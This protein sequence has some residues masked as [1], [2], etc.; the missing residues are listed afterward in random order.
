MQEQ[1]VQPDSNC[2]DS[3]SNSSSDEGLENRSSSSSEDEEE[4]DDS[5]QEKENKT[6]GGGEMED[7][8]VKRIVDTPNANNNNSPDEEDS[9]TADDAANKNGVDTGGRDEQQRSK[10]IGSDDKMKG[11]VKPV[12]HQDKK[13]SEHKVEERKGNV[14]TQEERNSR[15]TPTSH[16]GPSW[17]TR[18]ELEEGRDMTPSSWSGEELEQKITAWDGYLQGTLLIMSDYQKMYNNSYKYFNWNTKSIPW[19]DY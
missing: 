10:E 19:D 2:N 12:A 1:G 4:K 13:T 3:G 14:V 17:S 9:A 8:R 7:K 16:V 18:A 15:G 11:D 6:M 5:K